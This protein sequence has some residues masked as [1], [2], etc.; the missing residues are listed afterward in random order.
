MIFSLLSD[1]VPRTKFGQF[2]QRAHFRARSPRPN[3]ETSCK[4][5]PPAGLSQKEHWASEKIGC[6]KLRRVNFVAAAAVFSSRGVFL[7]SAL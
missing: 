2:G 4:G 5:T 1:Q 7:F 6:S 3:V